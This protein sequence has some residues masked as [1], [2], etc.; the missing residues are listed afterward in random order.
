MLQGKY[1]E[2]KNRSLLFGSDDLVLWCER[3]LYNISFVPI[4][5]DFFSQIC[6]VECLIRSLLITSNSFN[7]VPNRNFRRTG[8]CICCKS[9][10][11]MF[12]W[13]VEH[14]SKSC[15]SALWVETGSPASLQKLIVP[16]QKEEGENALH[17]LLPPTPFSSLAS[18]K[19]MSHMVEY[20]VPDELTVSIPPRMGLVLIV[21]AFT[22]RVEHQTPLLKNKG[23][24]A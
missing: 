13:D 2:N 17:I 7:N 14:M 5:I 24:K 10:L 4:F 8:C 21:R 19:M 1:A 15:T 22:H 3:K 6:V 18:N 9:V 20:V 11:M 12:C 23:F 16:G